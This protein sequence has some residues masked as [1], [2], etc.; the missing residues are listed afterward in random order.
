MKASLKIVSV[1]TALLLGSFLPVLR[2]QDNAPPPP[3]GGFC[4]NPQDGLLTMLTSKLA[5][6]QEQQTKIKT[7]LDDEKTAMDA[8]LDSASTDHD[9][10]RTKIDAIIQAHR[11]QIRI[12]LTSEQ[13]VL[14]DQLKPAGHPGP[15][16]P[17]PE[18][19]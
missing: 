5:L 17:P 10:V 3:P 7:I 4:H 8:L 1:T 9:A 2:A 15:G 18:I 6:T 11:E 13:Q 19:D 16:G 12:L 14:F